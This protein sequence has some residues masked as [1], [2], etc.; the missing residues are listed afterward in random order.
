M[1]QTKIPYYQIIVGGY[2]TY[3]L[4]VIYYILPQ[5]LSK[6][7]KKL[8]RK[9]NGK[10]WT[11]DFMNYNQPEDRD[12]NSDTWEEE[13][14]ARKKKISDA[15]DL[16]KLRSVAINNKKQNSFIII[17]TYVFRY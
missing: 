4:P 14:D 7:H 8:L 17:E 13:E 12:P 11:Y 10:S 5:D 1:A 3:E 15:F 2:N 9:Y 6:K 16:H